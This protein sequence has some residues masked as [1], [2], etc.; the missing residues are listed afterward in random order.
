MNKIWLTL[1]CLNC[2]NN[3]IIPTDYNVIRNDKRDSGTS[4]KLNSLKYSR[5]HKNWLE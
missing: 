4:L 1:N 2:G 5:D 3:P